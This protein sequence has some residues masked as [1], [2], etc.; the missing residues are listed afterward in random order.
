[1]TL[2]LAYTYEFKFWSSLSLVADWAIFE[3]FSSDGASGRATDELVKDRE[4]FVQRR[5]LLQVSF[6]DAMDAFLHH[7]IDQVLLVTLQYDGEE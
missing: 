2:S 6:N 5:V 1:M 4:A 3:R 7:D